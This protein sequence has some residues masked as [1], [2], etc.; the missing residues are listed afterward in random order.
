VIQEIDYMN[1]LFT[2]AY[3]IK[4]LVYNFS[5]IHPLILIS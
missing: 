1:N 2:S 5:L 3:I 4:K